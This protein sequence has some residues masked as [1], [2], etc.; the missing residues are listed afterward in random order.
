MLDYHLHS[1]V[2]H[3][4]QTAPEAIV[5]AALQAGLR[6]ICFTD[7]LDYLRNFPRDTQAFRVEDYNKSYDHLSA[8]G[9]SIRRGAEVSLSK[10]STPMV[11]H[12][13]RQRP[14]DFIIGSLHF[15]RDRDIYVDDEFWAEHP[16]QEVIRE[17]FEEILECIQAFDNFDVLGHLTYISKCPSN[18][19]R[20]AIEYRD[21]RDV[22]D[23][24]FKVLIDKGKGLEINTSAVDIIGAFLPEAAYL[25]RFKELGGEIITVGSDAHQAHRVGQYTGKACALAME[26]FGH[27]CTFENR[28]PIFHKL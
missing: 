9:L 21:H 22:V 25:R 10:W 2:S 11:E 5:Q 26:I 3:D 27:V 14:Y 16:Q 1:N 17:Y 28:R 18:P 12:D 8:P 20:C 23:E 24:I 6:E 19:N 4:S 7:H 15:L 13:L